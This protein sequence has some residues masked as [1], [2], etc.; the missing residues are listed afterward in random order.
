M[1]K[2]NI[3]TP[4]GTCRIHRP[5]EKN[6][7]GAT[8]S[9]I[10]TDTIINYPRIGFYHSLAE[11]TQVLKFLKHGLTSE[12]SQYSGFLF[13]KEPAE[14][15][16]NNIFNDRLW[17]HTIHTNI[18]TC[19]NIDGTTI[20]IEVSSLDSFYHP[21]S[22]LYFQRNPNKEINVSYSDLNN[23]SFY[24]KHKPDLGV[25]K[26]RATKTE[27]ID[28]LIQIRNLYPTSPIVVMGHINDHFS[29]FVSRRNLNALLAESCAMVNGVYFYDNRLVF[30][31]HG[32]AINKDG[33]TDINH[34]SDAAEVAL[35]NNFQKISRILSDFIMGT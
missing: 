25:L 16:P 35:G 26:K 9:N 19:D 29:Q 14:T 12:A 10:D 27:L 1:K 5:F 15:T 34:L 28:N 8:K 22:G 2:V 20:L 17:S 21:P 7:K 3:I 31:E 18:I 23:L 32:Y 24:D 13:R 4:F 30:E 33:T 6:V 11:I